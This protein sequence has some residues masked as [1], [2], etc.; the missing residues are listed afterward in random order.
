MLKEDCL[1]LICPSKDTRNYWQEIGFELTVMQMATI[2]VNNFNNYFDRQDRIV[3][4]SELLNLAE[5]DST[6]IVLNNYLEVEQAKYSNFIKN[7]IR[8]VYEV[9]SVFEK[10]NNEAE[11]ELSEGLACDFNTAML[12]KD[13]CEDRVSKIV[14]RKIYTTQNYD[15]EGDLATMEFRK[16][17]KIK[18]IYCHNSKQD[19]DSIIPAVYIS[20]PHNFHEGDIVKNKNGQWG[21]VESS[22]KPGEDFTTFEQNLK[23][24]WKVEYEPLIVVEH[25]NDGGQFYH[26]H[27]DPLTLERVKVEETLKYKF[28]QASG[29]LVTGEISLD[30]F[31]SIREEYLQSLKH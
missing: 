24:C 29:W 11:D 19:A 18:E 12:I 5:D 9:F 28:F 26:A 6:K 20:L 27:Y 30:Y 10:D 17:G 3:I 14:K 16:D 2:V 1:E 31:D 7:D 21:I 22:I 25:L 23:A 8:T 4:I 15:D 13:K